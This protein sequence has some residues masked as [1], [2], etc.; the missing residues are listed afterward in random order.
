MSNA[1][2]IASVTAVLKNL[3][4]NGM[5]EA[6]SNGPVNVD[7]SPPDRVATG[8][9][10]QA[11]LNLFLYSVAPN[12]GWRNVDLP[13]RDAQGQS[14]SNPPLAL[15]LYYLLSAYEADE[16]DAEILLGYAMQILHETP[17]LGR[18]AI[19]AALEGD[20]ASGTPPPIQFQALRASDLADQAEQIKITPH[21]LDVDEMSKL[22]T[23]FQAKYRPSVAYHVSVVLIEGTRPVRSALPVLSR[24]RAVPS[25]GRDEGV[26]VQPDLLPSV[27][28]IE[29][30]APPNGNP[31]VRLG[32]ELTVTGHHLDGTAVRAICRT[33]LL[34]EPV[35]AEVA[36]GGTST[37]LA[38]RFPKT[39]D[40]ADAWAIGAY[41]LELVM[42][43]AQ[44]ADRTTN[45]LPFALAPSVT[46]SAVADGGKVVIAVACTPSMRVGQRVALIVGDREVSAEIAAPTGSLAFTYAGLSTGKY[47]VCL[48]VDGIESLFIDRTKTPPRFDAGQTVEIT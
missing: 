2:A 18:A 35:E 27:P 23:A 10:E 32:E 25:E 22:W 15:D 30:I 16:Y 17:V 9:S 4:D 20:S 38:I 46:P 36:V 40:P 39:G 48:R 1:L 24:G 14:V 31:S 5:V 47:P 19:R 7:V 11:Q 33:R 42:K 37:E 12:L 34:T 21:R 8:A 43:D 41:T 28:T 29:S 6:N 26:A 45:A 13:S 3:L 44:G